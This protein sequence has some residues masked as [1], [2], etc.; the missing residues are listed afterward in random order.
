MKASTRFLVAT[1]MS[2]ICLFEILWLVSIKKGDIALFIFA[3]LMIAFICV[4]HFTLKEY[5]ANK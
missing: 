4:M 1:A 3:P 5:K 2:I